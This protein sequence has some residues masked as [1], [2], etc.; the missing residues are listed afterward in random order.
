MVYLVLVV[1]LGYG[2][3]FAGRWLIAYPFKN[4]VKF[5]INGDGEVRGN[6]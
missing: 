1:V 4:K 2:C 6:D 5:G 3:V